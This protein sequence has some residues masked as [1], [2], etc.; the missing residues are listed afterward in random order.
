M[1]APPD[2]DGGSPPPEPARSPAAARV[3][4]VEDEFLVALLL[5]EELRALGLSMVGPFMSVAAAIE[6]CR[7]EQYDLAILDINL[8]GEMV[9]PVADELRALGAPFLFVS[10]YGEMNLPERHRG[11]PCLA[12]PCD[13]A[14]LA[15]EVERLLSA[16]RRKQTSRPS[17]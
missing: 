16:H 4:V 13:Q 12:K 15:R 14:A 9:F 6:A 3:L 5:E 17:F 10:G 7:R 8:R 11:A 2:R 1:N